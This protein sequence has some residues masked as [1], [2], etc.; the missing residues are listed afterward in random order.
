M[1][2]ILNWIEKIRE[3][4]KVNPYIFT[5]IY[6]LSV[7]FFWYSLYKIVAGIKAHQTDKVIQWGIIISIATVAPFSYVAIFG[8]NLP[9]TFWIVVSLLVIFSFISLI[10]NIRKK[11]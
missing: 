3:E 9:S 11:L 4:Y 6:L 7:P 10:R 2:S 8:K 1:Q 5:V